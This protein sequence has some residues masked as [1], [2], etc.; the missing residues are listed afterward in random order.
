MN[1]V[2]LLVIVLVVVA[3]LPT[4]P[5]SREWGPYPSGLLSLV[6]VIFLIYFLMN[7]MHGLR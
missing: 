5:Y 1:I 6:L 3:V 4:W 2:I 7:N